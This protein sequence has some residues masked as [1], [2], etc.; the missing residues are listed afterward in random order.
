MPGIKFGTRQVKNPT[1]AGI[2]R[3]VKA[4][5]VSAALF[6]AWMPTN[7]IIGHH[8]QDIITP[9]LALLMGMINGVAPL[10]GIETT[11]KVV[12]MDEV[13]AMETPKE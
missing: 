12:N 7:N 10:F 13:T 3:F 8:A 9:I 11:S 5:N 1:P 4:F 2:E 6:I